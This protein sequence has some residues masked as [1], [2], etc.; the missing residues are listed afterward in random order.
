MAGDGPC[1]TAVSTMQE[2]E[3]LGTGLMESPT[4]L[5]NTSSVWCCSV[6][7]HTRANGQTLVA[8]S[9]DH[10]CA[11]LASLFTALE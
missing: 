4:T 11:T 2:R 3:S 1:V 9:G 6:G 7:L 5:K 10:L 8:K